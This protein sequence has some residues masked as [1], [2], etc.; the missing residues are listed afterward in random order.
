[1]PTLYQKLVDKIDE[2]V[3]LAGFYQD[4]K[5]DF[6]LEDVLWAFKASF[7]RERKPYAEAVA[8]IGEMLL[9]GDKPHWKMGEPLSKQSPECQ[10]SIAEILNIK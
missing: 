10:Q 5:E 9:S 3:P 8:I 1:M 6:S 4:G 2:L 7:L